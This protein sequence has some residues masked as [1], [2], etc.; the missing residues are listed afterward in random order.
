MADKD[1]MTVRAE[2]NPLRVFF[3]DA[4]GNMLSVLADTVERDYWHHVSTAEKGVA[5]KSYTPALT[6]REATLAVGALS[7]FRC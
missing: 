4:A 2:K 3:M 6:E 5:D 7:P 1:W